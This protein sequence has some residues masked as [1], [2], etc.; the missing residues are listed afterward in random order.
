MKFR[1]AALGLMGIILLAACQG[2]PSE[3]P[4]QPP[5]SPTEASEP[6]PEPTATPTP[7]PQPTVT[8][9]PSPTPAPPYLEGWRM[10]TGANS[11]EQASPD[12]AA[13]II[14]LPWV[15]DGIVRSEEEAVGK[16]V[17]AAMMDEPVFLA[18]IGKAWVMD[19]INGTEQDILQLLA[20]FKNEA[21][22]ALIPDMPFMETV[23][24]GDRFTVSRLLSMDSHD[25]TLLP[26][27]A[28][29]AWVRDGIAGTEEEAIRQ[30]R[31]FSNANVAVAVIALGWV[32]DGIEGSEID[33][34]E[35]LSR[36]DA[37]DSAVSASVVAL[38][39]VQ[40][41]VEGI[42]FDA[43]DW[44]DNFGGGE[45]ATAL[46]ASDWV[47]DSVT[48]LE[49]KAIE[50]LS[51]INYDDAEVAAS[52]IAL[53]WVEDGI[54]DLEFQAIDWINNFS[55][56][57][58]AP[59]VALGWVRDGIEELEVKAIEELSYIN[60]EDVEVAASVIALGWVED[61]VEQREV[62]TIQ[63]LRY[64]AM[65]DL[66]VVASV[67]ALPWV[68]D[69]IE[70]LEFQAIDWINNFSPGP[71][72]SS[73]VGLGWVE[74]GVEQRE[75]DT[76]Q[77]LS[78]INY[79][80]VGVAASVIALPWVEDG[81]EDLE[82]QA[83]DWINNFSDGEAAPVVALGW[84][85]DGIEELEV[86]AIEELSYINYEDVEVA[87][88]VIALGWVEDGVEQREVDTIQGLRYIAMD[89]LGVVASV[90][91]LP[92]VEDGIHKPETDAI[93]DLS[94]IAREDSEA[95]SRVVAMPFL[96]SLEA[97]DAAAL[98]SLSSMALLQ[99]KAF[100]KVLSHPTLSSGITDKW[101]KI[102]ATLYG[103][104]GTNSDLIDTLLNPDKVTLEERTIKLPMA[105]KT[106]LAI[107]RTGPGAERSMDLLEHAVRYAEEYM[108]EPFPTG[109]VGW[110]FGDAVTRGFAGTNFGT[111]FATLAKYD[112]DDGSHE[113][114]FTGSLTA[115]EVAHY[116]W[117]GNS[118][119][120]DE[121]AANFIEAVSEN[122]RIDAPV[123]VSNE[124]CGYVR[125]IAKLEV[126]DVTNQD[127]AESAFICNYSLGERLFLDLYR[128][129][130][131]ERFRKGL[132]E[133]YLLS[134]EV[135][136]DTEDATEVG[137]EHVKAAFKDVEGVDA[138]VVDTIAARWYDGTEPY[139]TSGRDTAQRI[140][141]FRTVNG[142]LDV[143]YLAAGE[144]GARA[145][146]FS[147]GSVDER[148]WMFLE[149]SYS[150]GRNTEVPLEIVTYYED[151]FVFDRKVRTFTAEPGYIGASWWIPVGASPENPWALGTYHVYVYN[152]GRKLVEL[153]YEVTE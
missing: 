93:A 106:L 109:Y 116:Y 70:D 124:P 10:I 101:A 20:G 97:P 71:A 99:K 95:A 112:V 141:H 145:T 119:W 94:W 129:L 144:R 111:H 37:D 108:E 77:E 148:V 121:G 23:E 98:Q 152:E 46:V 14:A 72:M 58:A 62:D 79:D 74:D 83:I 61:G 149:Y 147:A 135:Q 81:I 132:R 13:M 133:L 11:L 66:G 18:V 76:I 104:S 15:A 40:D 142:T 49:V 26:A 107:I 69:G 28:E 140:P 96:E 122:A 8:P 45:A 32:Q 25:P 85:R 136:E 42:E 113:A 64:I 33:A 105:G 52:V 60:Y 86:K 65:D 50:E 16:L 51:Y 138:S 38:P 55:D 67:V 89:D 110:L 100:G 35:E 82:F 151:G 150:V 30:L 131:E 84:V 29:L 56:G 123:E 143:A 91:A 5:S 146:S 153:E 114:D 102:V 34:I 48:E 137:I 126:L 63:E 68:E 27:L 103:V 24:P 22:A 9:A 118:S 39:W 90:V 7:V 78:Y 53:G 128:S 127:G 92:W 73:V 47:K 117:L 134:R 88:S 17:N 125:T 12:L 4:A 1:L 44:V 41:G 87:A 80:D 59:V 19:G 115:H 2:T 120:V 3:A 75:V 31:N 36:L 21:V 54:E 6:K 57:E 43:I 139:D 130:G